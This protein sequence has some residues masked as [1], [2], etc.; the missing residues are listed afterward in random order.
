M[1]KPHTFPTLYNEALQVHISKLKDWG[2][3][4]PGQILSGTLNW[5]RN[6]NPT[7][8]I[9]IKVCTL[10]SQ[11]YIELDYKYRDEPR[12]YK[13]NLTSTPSNL[14]RGEIWYFIC[15]QTKKRCRKLYS[16]GGYFLHREAFNGCMY[17]T[18]TQSKK[19]RQLDKTLGAYYRTDNL[20]SELYKK[21]FKKTYAGKPTKRYLRIMGQIRKAELL[22][23]RDIEK[24]I[25]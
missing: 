18:Q 24:M 5:S 9:S 1:P 15:P 23:I 6:G 20:Y 3:L 12:K 11:P 13:V 19:Y 25:F 2:Y 22:N 21:H 14:N 17:E 7:G 16:V 10:D 8:S 4:S